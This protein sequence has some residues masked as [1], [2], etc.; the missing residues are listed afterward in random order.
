M[1]DILDGQFPKGKCKERGAALVMLS[2][3]E[4]MLLGVK[5]D[6]WGEPIGVVPTEK[7]IAEFLD[8]SNRIEN[9]YS[10]NAFLQSQFAWDFLVAET[11]N[12]KLTIENILKMHK[13]LM[14][15]QPLKPN[16]KGYLRRVP[17]YIGGHEA[18][19]WRFIEE[20]LN[21]L[22]D[23]INDAVENGKKESETWKEKI[24]KDHHVQYEAIHPFVD[25]NG[26]TGRILMNWQR[27][28]LGLPIN[29]I[30]EGKEQMEYYKW[31]KWS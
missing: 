19:D 16:E 24:V 31:F 8:H 30:H 7:Q 12:D 4:M 9:E 13:I 14:L 23:N 6:D 27:I 21:H 26:R 15:N 28:K 10:D 25:G 17:V 20:K 1:V 29:I 11:L 2:Y 3:I 22:V 5:F 18:L